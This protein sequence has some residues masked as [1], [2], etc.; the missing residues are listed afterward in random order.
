ME[1]KEIVR[2]GYNKV[3]EKLQEI[4]GVKKEESDKLKLLDDF[5]SS[6]SK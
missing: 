1:Y 2:K 4:F 3:A 5:I 6:K